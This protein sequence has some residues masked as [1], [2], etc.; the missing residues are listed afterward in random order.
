MDTIQNKLQEA[1]ELIK[2]TATMRKLQKA[3]YAVPYHENAE[4]SILLTASKIQSTKVDEM[5]LEYYGKSNNNK[6][7]WK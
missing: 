1:N 5:I 6:S 3:Y 2:E 7:N 4:K